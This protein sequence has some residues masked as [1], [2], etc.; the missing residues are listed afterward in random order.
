MIHII[1][2]GPAGI[3]LAYYAFRKGIKKI[4]LYEKTNFIGG[5]S[6]SWKHDNFILDTGP[7]IFHT[8]DNEIASDWETIGKDILVAGSFNS[9]NILSNYPNKLFHYP[10]SISTLKKN[11]DEKEFRKIEIE[12]QVLKE[13]D[14]SGTASNFKNFLEAKVGKTLTEM[15]FTHYP[16]KVWG[17][18]TDQM[19]ADWAPQRISLRDKD[20]NFYT[21]PF[22]AVGLNGTGCFYD[23]II[24]LLTEQSDFKI[25]FGKDLTGID[26]NAHFID[27]LVFNNEEKIKVGKNDHVFSTIPATNLAKIFSLDLSLKFR[28]VRSQYFFFKND[29]IIPKGYNW[30]YCSDSNVSFNRITEPS[31]MTPGVSP[32]G[33]SFVCVETTFGDNWERELNQPNSEFIDWLTLNPKFNSKGYIKELN[34]QNF[35]RYVYPIQDK[36]FRSSLSKYNSLIS[37]YKNLSVLG[38]GGEFHYSDMQIIFRK[39]KTLID[40]YLQNYSNKGISPIPLIKNFEQEYKKNHTDTHTIKKNESNYLKTSKL[41]SISNV[42]IPLIAEIGINHNGDLNLAKK[43]M[44][45]AKNAGAHFAKFQYYKKDSRVQKNNLTEYLH[46]TADGTEMSLNDIFERARLN[47]YK[48]K[49]LIE[50]GKEIN[51]P[52]FFTVFDIESAAEIKEL[53][54]KIVKVASMDCNNLRLHNELNSLKFESIIISTG[55]SNISEI[56]RSLS[57]YKNRKDILLMSCRSSY[58]ARFED[59]DFGEINYLKNETNCMVG[60]SDH[61]EGDLA[62]LISIASGATFIERHFTTNKF[63]PGPDNRMS[64][65]HQETLELSKKLQIVAESM[66][67]EQK[68]IHPSEQTT[69]AMQKRSLRFPISKKKGDTIHTDELISVAPPEGY[70]IFQATLPRTN[71]RVIKDVVEGEPV[72]ELNVTFR[73]E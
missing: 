38:T 25:L 9:C 17:L 16:Q 26:K 65:D 10:L 7:H 71:L 22:V 12:L 18:K 13:I 32:K 55:M 52:V 58:P 59:I 51:I 36:D 56:K 3:S 39:S 23:R 31:T 44:L 64:I 63:L 66:S 50:Y 42:L 45:A 46:E 14:N 54:Q 67:K 70:S 15:F 4:T 35:E 8:S 21:K 37:Q 41:H 29:R 43:M 53:N 73:S 47:K 72:N 62:S 30:V 11:L 28:G 48:C 24:N 33:Y 20:A 5:M 49:E 6:R 69:F 57:I 1:G 27:R 34:T 60:F 40:S 61:T 2:A 68:I 19:L